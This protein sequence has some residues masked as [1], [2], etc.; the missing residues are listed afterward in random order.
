MIF[1]LSEN[2]DQFFGLKK[3]SYLTHL[4]R[5]IGSVQ[6]GTKFEAV[7]ELLKVIVQKQK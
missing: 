6:N 2:S 4:S 1:N 3:F 7:Y 5:N